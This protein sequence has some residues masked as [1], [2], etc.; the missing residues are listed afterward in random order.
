MRAVTREVFPLLVWALFAAFL[1]ACSSTTIAVFE[2][3]GPQPALAV[4]PSEPLVAAE[5][6]G[7]G[8]TDRDDE[9]ETTFEET[10]VE[11]PHHLSVVIA[12]THA[13]DENAFTLGVDY[14]YRL[15][16]FLGLGTVVEYAFEPFNATTL[17]AVADLHIWRGLAVQ[18]GPGVVFVDGEELFVYRIGGVYEFEFDGFTVSPQVHYEA[19]SSEADAVVFGIALGHSF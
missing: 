3:S 16:G 15:S 19:T 2:D 12:G 14:E 8:E 9:Q 1:V 13:V 6:T 10:W 11:Q 17:L 4:L 5:A 18:T 7:R